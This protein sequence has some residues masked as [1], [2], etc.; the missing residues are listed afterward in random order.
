MFD[1]KRD[2]LATLREQHRGI[3]HRLDLAKKT[4]NEGRSPAPGK[5]RKL[6]YGLGSKL[7][8]H[9]SEEEKHLY[10]PLKLRLGKDSPMDSMLREHQSIR[11]AFK[12]LRLASAEYEPGR[13]SNRELQLSFDSLQ[14]GMISHLKKEEKVLYW[15]AELKL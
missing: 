9:F 11:Q 7:Q 14:E 10:T 13:S 5:L 15:L 8:T 1:I 3:I 2:Q 4:I 6:V 12:R